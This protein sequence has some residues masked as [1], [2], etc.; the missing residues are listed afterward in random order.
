MN[1]LEVS[2]MENQSLISVNNLHQSGVVSHI[3]LNVQSHQSQSTR[4]RQHYYNPGMKSTIWLSLDGRSARAMTFRDVLDEGDGKEGD[5][6]VQLRNDQWKSF[7]DGK[8]GNHP[9]HLCNNHRQHGERCFSAN[10]LAVLRRAACH[11]RMK[12]VTS[13][14]QPGQPSRGTILCLLS[15]SKREDISDAS[16]KQFSYV[17]FSKLD[18]LGD[19]IKMQYTQRISAPLLG[20]RGNT[21]SAGLAYGTEIFRIL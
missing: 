17:D 13:P 3:S 12:W 15:D 1:R 9:R 6:N 18:A 16:S 21:L 4:S 14:V 20:R 8:T 11:R 19:V 5:L 2:R 7:M 10:D